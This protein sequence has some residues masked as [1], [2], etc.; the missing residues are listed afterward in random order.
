M[1]A[2]DREAKRRREE[3]K[4]DVRNK[5]E[6][7][8][9]MNKIT[10]HRDKAKKG[11][12]REMTAEKAYWASNALRL[13]SR[14]A[15]LGVLVTQMRPQQSSEKEKKRQHDKRREEQM[16]MAEQDKEK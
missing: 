12:S 16:R 9:A 3:K 2:S 4:S 5:K 1:R 15:R 6:K 8:T 14:G 13:Y 10:K 7:T 11:N